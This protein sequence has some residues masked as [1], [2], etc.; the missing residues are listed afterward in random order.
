MA[1]YNDYSGTNKA[2]FHIGGALNPALKDAGS[3]VLA[4]LEHDETTL[5]ELRAAKILESPASETAVPTLLDLKGRSPDIVFSFDGASAPSPGANAQTFGMCHTSGG[6]FTAGRIYYDSTEL[7]ALT[8]IPEDVGMTIT[9]KTAVTGTKSF[10][11]NSVYAWVSSCTW[12]K[13]GD[14]GGTATGGKTIQIDLINSDTVK[15]STYSLVSTEIIEKV[16][17][18]ISTPFSAGG[19]L[20][21]ILDGTNNQTLFDSTGDDGS[22]QLANQYEINDWYVV[23]ALTAGKITVTLS[24]SPAAG[25]CSVFVICSPKTA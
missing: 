16:I 1:N 13:R 17:V 24:G 10:D 4:V 8:L 12:G 18:R 14:A 7:T 22:M 6:G 11:A 3:Q 21:V 19:E 2:V 25:V 5:A 15:Q 9:V 20:N 23:T